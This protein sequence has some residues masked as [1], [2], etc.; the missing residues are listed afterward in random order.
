MSGPHPLPSRRHRRDDRVPTQP[1]L[2]ELEDEDED[3]R[4]PRRVWFWAVVVLLLIVVG[5]AAW[6][7]VRGYLAKEELQTAQNQIGA[8]KKQALAFDIDAAQHTLD[9][10]AGHTSSA[11]ALTS[12][13]VWRIG[14]LIPFAGPNLVAVREL[15]AVTDDTI[16]EVA[17]PLIS[18][19]STI[20]PA[21]FQPKDGA[22]DLA[23]FMTAADPV[24]QANAALKEILVRADAVPE[25]G[26]LALIADARTKVV[27]M[28]G[29]MAPMLSTLDTVVPLLPSTMGADGPRYYALMFQNPAEPRALG[30]AALS[31]TLVELDNGKISLKETLP[32]STGAFSKYGSSVIPIPDGAE[33]VYPNGEFGTFIVEASARPSFTTA[34]EMV[35]ETW[36]RQFGQ[37][38]DGV[39]SIDPVALSY[40]LRATG[41]IETPDGDTLDQDS[42][43]PLL[44]NGVY[45]RYAAYPPKEANAMHDAVYAQI[46]SSVF[47]ALT[48]GALDPQQL[49]GALAQGWDERRI[50]FWSAHPEEEQRLAATGLNGEMPT[51]DEATVRAGLYLQDSVGSK[52]SFYLRQ[53]VT[54][55]HG[56]CSGDERSYYRVELDLTNTIDPVVAPELPF[57]ITGEWE[58]EGLAPGI[59]RMTIRLYAPPGSKIIGATVDGAPISLDEMH[60]TDY[61]VGKTL[62]AVDP[63]SRASLVYYFSLDGDAARGFEAQVT[64]LVTPTKVSTAPLDCG[65][66]PAL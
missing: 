36:K 34:G 63:G 33:V 4:P 48:S 38:L 13:P 44:L 46:V 28:L 58:R 26:T 10:I 64:P 65:T 5:S 51:T 59:N 9:E 27:T 30:G 18:V 11:A 52:L 7:G 60:D 50:L 43:V 62:I 42:L 8:L 12:D 3:E 47:T 41:P 23:P 16:D 53:A 49:M 37:E 20:D 21:S 66:I 31:F 19:A 35:S 14:E 15:A 6:I 61:P 57:H 40:V 25:D 32:A 56:Q 39:L 45:L 1:D 29:D 54:L 17:R 22:I 55:S 2:E 24:A